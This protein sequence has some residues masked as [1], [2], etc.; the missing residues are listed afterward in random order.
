MASDLH[1]ALTGLVVDDEEYKG[2]K[3]RLRKSITGY[4]VAITNPKTQFFTNT[5]EEAIIWIKDELKQ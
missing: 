1:K 5:A 4:I 3:V 2:R